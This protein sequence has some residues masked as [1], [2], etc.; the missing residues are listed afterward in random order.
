MKQIILGTAGHIDHGKTS[1]IK[2]LTGIDTDRLKEEKLRGITIELGFAWLDLPSGQRVGIVDV[3][4]HEKFVKNMV[5]GASGIDM[6]ALIIAADEGVMPQ[7]TE[8]LDICNVLNIEHG[9]VVLTKTDLVDEEWLELIKEDVGQ[10]LKG[11]FLE[12]AP[13]VPVSSATGQ[14]VPELLQTLDTICESIP[15][16]TA[17]GLFRLPVDRVFTM[18]GFGTVITGSLVSGSVQVGETVMIYPSGIQAKVRGIQ[19]HGEK[20]DQASVGMRTAIN[21]QAIDR[22]A[23]SRGDVI[24]GVNRLKPSFMVDT[25]LEYLPGN[26][27]AL[28]NRTKVRFH[29]GTSEILGYAI[30]LDREELAP[31]EAASAQF[32]LDSPVAAMKDD[33]FVVRS[34]SP[35]RTIG[36]GRILNPIPGKHKR[37]KNRILADFKD[38]AES[39]PSEIITLHLKSSGLLGVGLSDLRLLANLGEKELEGLIQQLL[40]QKAVVEVDRE[41]RIFIHGAVLEE[42][43]RKALEILG[44]YHQEHPLKVGMARQE[45]MSRLS[46]SLSSKLF[47]ILVQDLTASHAAV[48]EKEVIRLPGHSVALGA[49][50][51]DLR[52]RIERA[53]LESGLQPPYFRDMMSSLGQNS[54]NAKE[55]LMHML[56]EGILVKVK[57][58][59]YFHRG[60]I[61]DLKHKLVREWRVGVRA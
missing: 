50:E 41:N 10:F 56:K 21:F 34:Y 5:A 16:R 8:H 9:L 15:D 29:T 28:K 31:G 43:R 55:I 1:L 46:P 25:I 22:N 7:T 11:T 27:K 26:E 52:R 35:I 39:D 53:Y 32:R 3:P 57:E 40:S 54:S 47:N 58:D 51:E 36:G 38:L 18:K 49:D 61:E 23:I 17:G 42:L 59:L 4:G 19:F 48:Q 12:G 37:F 2:A 60:V 30:L 24:G 14:G 13:M 33:R 20:V 45:L 44:K 6:V